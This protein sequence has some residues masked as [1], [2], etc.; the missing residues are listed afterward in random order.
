MGFSQ[1]SEYSSG[2]L[3]ECGF[4]QAYTYCANTAAYKPIDVSG[5][6]AAV[7]GEFE[8]TTNDATQIL[9]QITTEVSNLSEEWGTKFASIDGA[10]LGIVDPG[11]FNDNMQKITS[12]ISDKQSE[13]SK[14]VSKIVSKTEEINQYLSS[15][16][17]VYQEYL[18]HKNDRDDLL[19]QRNALAD[20]CNASTD[21]GTIA[22]LKGQIAELDSR[23]DNLEQLLASYHELPEPEGSWVLA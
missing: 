6:A 18:E 9:D 8:K 17:E 14:L 12:D 7:D 22:S 3:P 5:L 1:L 2:S 13:C 16:D 4:A 23:L 20:Q 11:S 21:E 15:L 10:D 19:V